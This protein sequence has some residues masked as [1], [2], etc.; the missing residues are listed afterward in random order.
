MKASEAQVG[1]RHYKKLP[2]QP[3][4]YSLENGLNAAQHTA[5]KYITRHRDGGGRKDLYKAIHCILLLLE[6]EY[7]WKLG[8]DALVTALTNAALGLPAG[9]TA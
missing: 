5:I 7:E 4:Q 1:G 6:H 9:E 2:I 8:D 3:M